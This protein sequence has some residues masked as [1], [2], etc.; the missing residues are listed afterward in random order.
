MFDGRVL[1]QVELGVDGIKGLSE[2]DVSDPSS[3]QK[4]VAVFRAVQQ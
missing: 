1:D 2:F 3:G 4:D